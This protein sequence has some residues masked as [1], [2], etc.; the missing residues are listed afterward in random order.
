MPK[1]NR[2]S[3]TV[4]MMTM[5]AVSSMTSWPSAS[6]CLSAASATMPPVISVTLMPSMPQIRRERRPMRSTST[7]PPM[8]LPSRKAAKG[9]THASR[10]PTPRCLKRVPLKLT[11]ALMPVMIWK[12]CI[13]QPMMMTLRKKGLVKTSLHEASPAFSSSLISART[14]S[15]SLAASSRFDPRSFVRILS[16]SSERPCCSRKRGVSLMKIRPKATE[17]PSTT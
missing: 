8:A 6:R 14:L 2:K 13:R 1:E 16:A 7:K 17:K 5:P 12:N 11:M 9:N 10:P 15:S 4:P 3:T